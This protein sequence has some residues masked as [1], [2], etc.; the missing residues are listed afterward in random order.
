MKR[1]LVIGL[2]N[3]ETRF[4]NTY[5][6]VGMLAVKHIAHQ[7]EED[8]AALEW[9]THKD[10]FTYAVAADMVLV[11][12]LVFMNESGVA[13]K[14]ALKKFSNTPEDLVLIH[15]ES[16]LPIGA[17]RIS[18]GKNSAGHK[19]VES[20]MDML[21]TKDFTRVRIGIRPPAGAKRKKASEFVLAKIKPADLKLL[22]DAFQKIAAEFIALPSA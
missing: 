18:S 6:N 22:E 1:K 19:G 7:L 21:G 2:G 14:E 15:D 9:K 5:H 12:P 3:P 13:V 10:L 8:G 20:T 17:Y 11:T 16:D 4:K